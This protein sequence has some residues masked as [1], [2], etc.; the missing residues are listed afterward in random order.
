MEYVLLAASAAVSAAANLL[1]GLRRA[2]PSRV[3][4]VKLDHLGDLVTA[5]P[6]FAALR[7]AFPDAPID[8]LVGPW[9][10]DVLNESPYVS[11]VYI[12]DSPRF[13]RN[14]AG[15]EAVSGAQAL[16]AIAAARYT[17]IVELRGDARTLLLPFRC[18]SARRV[19]RGSVRIRH[20]LSRRRI[21]AAGSPP[22][23]HEV[24][25][26]LAAVRPWL[27]GRPPSDRVQI[28]LTPQERE[29]ARARL[30]A[31]GVDGGRPLVVLHPGAAWR[32]RAWSVDR[33]AALAARLRRDRGTSIAFVGG[34]DERDLEAALRARAPDLPAAYVFDAPLRESLAL[35]AEAS[36]F[37]G[38]DSGLVH[39]AAAC[40]TPVV[41][42]Y[43]PQDPR[44]FGPWTSRAA[45]LHKPVPCFPCAQKRCV[46]PEQPCVNLITV[47][48]VEAAS[49]RLL[50]GARP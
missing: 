12:Y 35:I 9:N 39:A 3:L 17:H 25:S 44:R 23:W 49:A 10:R 6:V 18:R 32:P 21:G 30:R 46:R 1:G 7:E 5:T 37:V 45:V 11:K 14:G 38:S 27:N 19:D 50:A 26:N 13:R 8:A 36:L 33:F 41:A 15:T 22:P 47:E 34:P 31:A 40:G 29:S 4:V 20:W 28:F 42:L 2:R 48:E 16:R 43:G 24:E